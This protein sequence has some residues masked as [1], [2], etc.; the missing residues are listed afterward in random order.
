MEIWDIPIEPLEERYSTQWADWFPKEFLRQGN[1][2]LQI[3]ASPLTDTIENGSF[4]DCYGTHYWK[5]NQLQTIMKRLY[6][7]DVPDAFFF[8]D[9]WFPGIESLAYVRD[10]M[11][12]KFKICGY[13]HAGSYDDRD[14]LAQAGMQ[15][16]AKD[17]EIG[18]MKIY[19]KIFVGS[20]YHKDLLCNK[21][22]CEPDKVFPIGYPIDKKTY[23]DYVNNER[24]N[25]IV[26]PHRLNREKRPD[27]FDDLKKELKDVF[28][29][30]TWVK[31]KE[32][33]SNKTEYYDILSRAKIAISFAEQETFGIA[34]AEAAVLGCIPITPNKLSY[35][36]TM[37]W[38]WRF[39]YFDDAI[40]LVRFALKQPNQRYEYPFEARY[41]ISK[42][43]EQVLYGIL[44]T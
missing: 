17:I 41:T 38:Q 24:E 19:D 6:C 9:L 44:H 20:Q 5:F 32:I 34:M 42:I 27:L 35:L 7:G 36:D 21:R 40:Q 29:E 26:F 1:E 18:W 2:V 15:S 16:W 30:Y 28:P 25:I 13:L 23:R 22:F 33:C 11:G 37:E 8:H 14:L 39:H 12:L 31:T 10:M 43:V 4:L 3:L